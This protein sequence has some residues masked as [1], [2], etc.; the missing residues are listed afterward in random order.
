M[1][2]WLTRADP[3]GG[4]IVGGLAVGAGGGGGGDVPVPES[5][6]DVDISKSPK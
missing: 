4:A 5:V 1:H 6:Q 3:C 2:T